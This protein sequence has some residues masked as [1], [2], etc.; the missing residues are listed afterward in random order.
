MMDSVRIKWDVMIGQ[1]CGCKRDFTKQARKKWRCSFANCDRHSSVINVDITWPDDEARGGTFCRPR[2][3]FCHC[4]MMSTFAVKSDVY[5]TKIFRIAPSI[6]PRV[7][8]IGRKDTSDE[9][10]DCERV[11]GIV[12]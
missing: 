12:A 7:G 5:G 9:N 1:R 8:I 6:S 10:D 11:T 3:P 2:A 4:P